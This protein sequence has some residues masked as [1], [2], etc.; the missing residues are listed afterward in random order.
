MN[1]I[2]SVAWASLHSKGE[3]WNKIEPTAQREWIAAGGRPQVIG[4]SMVGS[5]GDVNQGTTAGGDERACRG[6]SVRSS[7][8]TGNDRGAK[9][10][11]KVA[12]ESSPNPTQ[13]GRGSAARLFASEQRNTAPGPGRLHGSGRPNGMSGTAKS[14]RLRGSLRTSGNLT[15][16]QPVLGEPSPLTGKPDAG[17]PPVRFDEGRGV[18]REN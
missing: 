17:N 11:R 15:L 9:G 18:Q 3:A 5:P 6:Q 10:R 7:Q 8:E 1:S 4:D 13:K 12:C 16:S 14:A 2:R